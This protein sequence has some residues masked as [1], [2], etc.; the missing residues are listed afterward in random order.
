MATT[1]RS[2]RSG[3]GPVAARPSSRAAD[4]RVA[5]RPG[6]PGLADEVGYERANLVLVL[7]VAQVVQVLVLAG[8]VFVFF[9]VFGGI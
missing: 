5:A 7:V 3:S 4:E 9:M 8:A 6:R 1:S 2:R